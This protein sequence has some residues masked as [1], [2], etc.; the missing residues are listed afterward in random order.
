MAGE[1]GA[2][3]L[4]ETGHAVAGA[5]LARRWN[6]PDDLVC[7][8]LFHH[9]GLRI[10]VHPQMKRSPVA[11]VALSALLPD[12]LRQHLSG[13]ELLVKLQEKWP[14]FRLEELAKIVDE[15]QQALGLG[16]RND[17]PLSRRCR[18][19]LGDASVY[20]DGTLNAAALR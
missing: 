2:A 1:G 7:C 17:F 19:A 5:S 20:N 18:P 6:L 4:Q 10:L 13:L 3:P 16:V 14:A 9:H 8:I 15:K 11:A 12:Q